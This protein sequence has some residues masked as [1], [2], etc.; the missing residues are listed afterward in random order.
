MAVI[1]RRI[2]LHAAISIGGRGVGIAVN[3]VTFLYITRVLGP[4]LFGLYALAVVFVTMFATVVDNGVNIT[5]SRLLIE[6]PEAA[7]RVLA[8]GLVLKLLGSAMLTG[9]AIAVAHTP[10]VDPRLREIVPVAAGLI[11]VTGLTVVNAFFQA[12]VEMGWVVTGDLVNRATFLALAVL[13]LSRGG[14]VRS[15][16]AAQV[17]ATAVGALIPAGRVVRLV[18]AAFVMDASV[19]RAIAT[20]ALALSVSLALGM[21]T[22]RFDALALSTRVAERELG[23]YAAAFR[24]IDL[25]QLVPGLLLQVV[26]PAFVHDARATIASRYARVTGVLLV[27]ALPLATLMTVTAGPALALT[28]GSAYYDG[29]RYLAVLVWGMVAVFMGSAMLYVLVALQRFWILLAWSAFGSVTSVILALQFVSTFGAGGAAA[30]TV[31]AHTVVMIGLA[32]ALKREGVAPMPAL[33]PEAVGVAAIVG[34]VAGV[35]LPRLG[36]VGA[37]AV[38]AGVVAALVAALPRTRRE[39]LALLRPSS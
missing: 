11:L 17:A 5:V 12:R 24:V 27:V 29:G 14:G 28:A 38:A 22:A 32:W 25:L 9:A 35:S 1:A 2:A 7:A 26:F 20:P 33:V 36:L 3:A 4:E 31:A 19:W 39:L 23:L 34:I 10:W 37:V 18:G 8:N 16:L 13:V 15:L 30:S 6:R 21:I